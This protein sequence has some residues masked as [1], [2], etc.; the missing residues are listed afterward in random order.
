MDGAAFDALTDSL[1]RSPA[2]AA[3]G[4]IGVVMER[5]G[6]P[7]AAMPVGDDCAA[8]AEIGRAHV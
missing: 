8:I 6:L 7:S 3:K 4:D 1:R 2:L 5:L